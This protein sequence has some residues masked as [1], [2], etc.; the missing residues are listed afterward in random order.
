MTVQQALKDLILGNFYNCQRIPRINYICTHDGTNRQDCESIASGDWTKPDT[1]VGAKIVKNINIG[2]ASLKKSTAQYTVQNVELGYYDGTNYTAYFLTPLPTARTVTPGDILQ[3][4]WQFTITV[5]ISVSG[6]FTTIDG[7]SIHARLVYDIT[8]NNLYNVP[9]DLTC[10]NYIE[11]LGERGG[12]YYIIACTTQV[13]RDISRKQFSHP[14]A[15][16]VPDAPAT[17]SYNLFRACI[18]YGG[19]SPTCPSPIPYETQGNYCPSSAII[20]LSR[21]P[22][23]VTRDYYIKMS[24]GFNVS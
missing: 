18:E 19:P 14:D 8:D 1:G 13:S 5:D 24:G 4:E 10:P 11:Y 22:L 9:D 2:N 20:S 7:H 21:S 3:V 6:V 12:Y 23:A 15:Q 17:E 16:F